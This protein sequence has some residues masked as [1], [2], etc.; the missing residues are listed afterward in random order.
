MQK[1]N[2]ASAK[3]VKFWASLHCLSCM[4]ALPFNIS[5]SVQH[6]LL[7]IKLFIAYPSF[8]GI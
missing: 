2:S 1:R 3:T 7:E 8:I 6:S 4:I 5:N